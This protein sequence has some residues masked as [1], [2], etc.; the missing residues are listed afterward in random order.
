M[1]TDT[2]DSTVVID[3]DNTII[4]I[5]DEFEKLD[6]IANELDNLMVAAETAHRLRDDLPTLK[7]IYQLGLL[8][9]VCLSPLATESMSSSE[10][11]LAMENMASTVM[12]KSKEWGTKVLSFAKSFVEKAKD[13]TNKIFDPVISLIHNL[14]E[15]SFPSDP[16]SEKEMTGY[17]W[18][19]VSLVGVAMTSVVGIMTYLVANNLSPSSARQVVDKINNIKWP[20]G[21]INAKLKG[22]D[23]STSGRM[24]WNKIHFSMG[25]SEP[26]QQTGMPFE[27]GWTRTI[28]EALCNTVVSMKEKV[29]SSFSGIGNTLTRIS[30]YS[31]DKLS[32]VFEEH[33]P[34]AIA[35]HTG[36]E[37]AGNVAAF[38][39]RGAKYV[40]L[41]GIVYVAWK[42]F[43][44][45]FT[46]GLSVISH[47]LKKISE[48]ALDD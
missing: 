37:S 29:L 6:G 16:H 9:S 15:K 44:Y 14:K 17:N 45:I 1:D 19:T 4:D 23:N 21:G 13:V 48:A 5:D 8:S 42:L 43:R 34:N 3:D 25:K 35:G 36:R 46:K 28:V 33:I 11:E 32:D 26:S 38:V 12:E 2:S 24:Q 7:K 27:L 30:R 18:K 41:V 47:T 22:S 10:F 31:W 40:A 39:G 20:F